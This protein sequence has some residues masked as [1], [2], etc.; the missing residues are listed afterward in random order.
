MSAALAEVQSIVLHGNGFDHV[1]HLPL[2]FGA[3]SASMNF[4][5]HVL[6]R[7]LA[8]ALASTTPLRPH[9]RLQMNL[10]LS[11][12]GLDA[13]YLPRRVAAVLRQRAPAFVQG[14]AARAGSRLGDSAESSATFWD[15]DFRD[16]WLHL[17]VTLHGDDNRAL[18]AECAAL[19]TLADKAGVLVGTALQ[20]QRLGA[21]AGDTGRQQWVHFGYRDALA[22]IAVDGWSP[23]PPAG[24]TLKS[25]SSHR[26]GEFVLGHRQN[27]GANP[28]ALA[29]A[30][31]AVR[32]FYAGASFGALRV[33]EQDEQAFDNFVEAEAA[34]LAWPADRSD[35]ARDFIKA[36]LLGRWPDGRRIV[37]AP[38][39]A[40]GDHGAE[41][42]F[43]YAHDVDGY[44]CPFAGH[45]RRMNPRADG[46]RVHSGRNRPLMRRGMPY[47]PRYGPGTKHADRG[48][49]GLFFCASLEDQFEHLVGQWGAT[50]PLGSPDPGDASDPFCARQGLARPRFVV[51]RPGGG[52]PLVLAPPT[53]L[54]TRGTAYLLYLSVVGLQM[55]VSQG[56]WREERSDEP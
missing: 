29:D 14:A 20:G 5:H 12:A 37:A 27:S 46:A 10:G 30:P 52:P 44:G 55:L 7:A 39:Q 36:K 56:P 21:P 31:Q 24:P 35:T 2:H 23:R 43:D 22:Q 48:L 1:C 34:R 8:C 4:M 50:V 54:R 19:H 15:G 41:E 13:L 40:P 38:W 6:Q 28:W 42:D 16:D 9:P 45:V 47:G 18:A 3:G 53:L 26:A 17:V 32:R 51:P 11:F 49:L 25:F 33:I